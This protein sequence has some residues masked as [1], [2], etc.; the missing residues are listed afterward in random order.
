MTMTGT[1]LAAI[2]PDFLSFLI[3]DHPFPRMI[4]CLLLRYMKKKSMQLQ[5]DSLAKTKAARNGQELLKTAKGQRPKTACPLDN[6]RCT[7]HSLRSQLTLFVGD[8]NTLTRATARLDRP[9]RPSEIT[10]MMPTTTTP[11]SI[12]SLIRR[13]GSWTGV[14]GSTTICVFE[15]MDSRDAT[16]L[17]D[18]LTTS[19][20]RISPS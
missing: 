8:S 7:V 12:T 15:S 5:Q 11:N 16:V 17:R 10:E 18:S 9:L 4:F 20:L 19:I 1:N 14:T 13:T 2:P 3:P 6:F